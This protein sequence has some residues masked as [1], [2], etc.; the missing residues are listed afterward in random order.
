V[1]VNVVDDVRLNAAEQFMLLNARLVDRLRYA[2]LFRGAPAD[3]AVASLRPYQ[4]PDGGFGHALEPD[5]RTPLSQ[6]LT[7]ALAFEMLDE[8]GRFDDDLVRPACDY[9]ASISRPDGGVPF[10]HASIRPHPRAP[11]WQPDEEP[12]GSLLPTAQLAGLLHKHNVDHPWL[13]RA[14]E[15]CWRRAAELEQTRAYEVR[16]LV[17]FLDHVPGR[18]RAV[19]T[20]ER[21]GRLVFDQALVA[22]EVAAPGEVH[23]PLDFAV[24][25]D[26]LARRW[27]DDRLIDD[28][29]DALI[30][31][32]QPDGGWTINWQVWTPITGFEWRGV[33]TVTYLTRLARYGRLQLTNV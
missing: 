4:N 13:E 15:F 20:A 8:L 30:D 24:S 31:N 12:V 29:L 11:W 2:H 5:G 23:T 33:V 19:R 3:Q 16:S 21:L 9:L 10:V 7:T 25:P 32:Q 17:C 22:L 26:S 6:P 1:P 28:H 18:S 27:F 14:T